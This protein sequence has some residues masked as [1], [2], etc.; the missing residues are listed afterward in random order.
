MPTDVNSKD[1]FVVVSDMLCKPG[2]FG[3][4]LA[5]LTAALMSTADTLINAVSVIT[6][7][8]FY[9]PYIKRD[10]PDKHYLFVARIVSVAGAI[11]VSYSFRFI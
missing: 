11:L 6:V 4:I 9:K 7:N 3:I 1:V 5:A 10:A 2:V 8:D